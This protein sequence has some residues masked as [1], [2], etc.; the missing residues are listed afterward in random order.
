MN[1]QVNEDIV[2]DNWD[3]IWDKHYVLGKWTGLKRELPNGKWNQTNLFLN[4]DD[5]TTPRDIKVSLLQ[6]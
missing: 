3:G 1:F 4:W 2:F 5:V 6:L